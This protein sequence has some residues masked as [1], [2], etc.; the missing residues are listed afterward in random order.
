MSIISKHRV[1]IIEDNADANDSLAILLEM[2][3]LSVAQALDGPSALKL[4]SE[5]DPQ[6]VLCDVGLP[7]MDGD[8]VARA[9]RVLYAG[10]PLVIAALTGYSDIEDQ[11]DS[12]GTLFDRHFTK[13]IGHEQLE[14][15]FASF[16]QGGET[17]QIQRASR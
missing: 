10:R 7:G 2:L 15:F 11:P 3:G 8:E 13:P 12:V 9:L 14:F 1:L 16:M 17:P 6:V 5:F 4:A